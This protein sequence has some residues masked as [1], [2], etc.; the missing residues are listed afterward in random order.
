MSQKCD[1][2]SIKV[3][4]LPMIES[5]ISSVVSKIE[6]L[7][8]RYPILFPVALMVLALVTYGVFIISLGFYWDDWPPILL[9]HVPDKALVWKYFTYDRPFQ[10]WTYYLQFFICN[11]STF[12]WQ[13]TGILVRWSAGLTLFYAF[14]GV[15]PRQKYLLQWAAVL[16]V[17]FPGF[18]DQ[19]A[20]VA[21]GSH[22]MVYTV[23]GFSLLFMVLSVKQPEK[24]WLFFPLA[25]VFTTV[26]L[27]TMEYFVGLEVLRP[28]MLYWLFHDSGFSKNKSVKRALQYWL[29]F[30]VII[31]VYLYWRMAIYPHQEFGLAQSNY[32]YIFADLLK[33]PIPTI[34][35]LIQ[36]IYADFHFLFVDIWANRILPARVELKSLPFWFSMVVGVG[37]AIILSLLFNGDRI[38]QRFTLTKN[39]LARN[40]VLSFT[41]FIF[42]LFPIWSSLRQV[43]IGKW[44]DRFDLPVI[45]GVTIFVITSLFVVVSSPKIRRVFLILLV[46][47]S[48]SF[49]IQSGYIY[50]KNYYLEKSFYTQLSWRIPALEPGSVI[51]APGI[52]TGRDTDYSYSMGLNLLFNTGSIDPTLDYWFFTP[53]NYKPVELTLNPELELTDSLRIFSF[54]GSA[55]KV[56]SVFKPDGGC[57]RVIDHYFAI[58]PEKIDQLYYYGELTNQD[59]ISDKGQPTNNLANIISTEPQNTWCYFFEKGDLA[60]SKGNYAEAVNYY[61]QAVAKKLVPLSSVELLPFIKAYIKLDRIDEAIAL[62]KESYRRESLS[63][64]AVCQVWHDSIKENSSITQ[65]AV[66]SIYNLDICKNLEP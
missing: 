35:Q 22:F 18:A 2:S 52:P 59:L 23:F 51:Y 65:T 53:R 42:G 17:V 43:T 9:L 54:Q 11:D 1:K 33:A 6:K 57:L 21:Y 28:V 49:Q 41:I 13:L 45:Y 24:F 50:R 61:E 26:H 8:D 55:S 15:I 37:L 48:I 44:S 47:L 66:E 12:L 16:F 40:L 29:P 31:C 38:Q 3:V 64:Q 19:Y 20:S 27:F 32:P 7:S 4:H 36:R 39:E 58:Y 60:Q 14:L 63:Y 30:F 62:T 10:S 25:L 46:G 5:R 56:I 34:M